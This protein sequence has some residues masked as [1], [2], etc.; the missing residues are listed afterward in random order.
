VVWR[1]LG[2][3]WG[4]LGLVFGVVSGGGLW[5]VVGGV[6]GGGPN[7]GRGG[8]GLVVVVRVVSGSGP[9]VVHLVQNPEIN[10]EIM[11]LWVFYKPFP[12]IRQLSSNL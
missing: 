4:G 8:G 7:G 12:H 11:L 10:F 3:V 1:G 2:V 6:P 5:V 9:G